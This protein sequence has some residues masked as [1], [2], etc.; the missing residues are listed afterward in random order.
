MYPA[1][2]KCYYNHACPKNSS[3]YC[4]GTNYYDPK[5]RSWYKDQA[6]K[7][8][9]KFYIFNLLIAS[10]FGDGYNFASLGNFGFT[11]CVPLLNK[12]SYNGAFC[13]DI[14][15]SPT[16]TGESSF[17]AENYFSDNQVTY[18]I[19]KYFSYVNYRN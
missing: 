5:C 17:I 15:P 4:S 3:S 19:A 10:T 2:V 12:T 14:T 16:L 11:H 7:S 8:E 6:L 18:L 9:S 13:T 1:S